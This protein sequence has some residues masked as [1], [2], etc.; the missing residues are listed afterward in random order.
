MYFAL[1]KG[2]VTVNSWDCRMHISKEARTLMLPLNKVLHSSANMGKML[3]A[4]EREERLWDGTGRIASCLYV[5]P[6]AIGAVWE[7]S[8]STCEVF[9]LWLE[10]IVISRDCWMIIEDQ[11]FSPSYTWLLPH[12]LPPHP[13]SSC[14][15]FSVFLCVAGRAYWQER[16]FEGLEEV[17]E[18][19]IIRQRDSLVLY[20][21]FKLSCSLYVV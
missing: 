1:R 15:C 11:S 8:A 12:P 2:S 10:C 16:G 3:P 13:S 14:L 9:I 7:H 17:G 4:T 6:D 20:K 5:L 21:S 19:P 18:E